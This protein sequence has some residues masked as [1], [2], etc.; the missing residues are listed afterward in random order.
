MKI[1]EYRNIYQI[2]YGKWLSDPTNFNIPDYFQSSSGGFKGSCLIGFTNLY[3]YG[4]D[5]ITTDKTFYF[6]MN[7]NPFTE[8][9]STTPEKSPGIYED[10][11]IR[12]SILC[13]D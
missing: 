9:N 6:N 1:A 3:I 5:S 10:F 8:V 2:Y 7:F 13:F 11:Y 4:K 12:W